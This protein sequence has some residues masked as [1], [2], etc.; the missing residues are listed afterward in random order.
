MININRQMVKGDYRE[1]VV[2][3]GSDGLVLQKEY[4]N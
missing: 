1:K 2:I 3:I 4:P